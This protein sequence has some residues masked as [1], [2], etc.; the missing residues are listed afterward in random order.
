MVMTKVGINVEDILEEIKAS[1]HPS[2]KGRD[3]TIT[4][5]SGEVAWLFGIEQTTLSGWVRNNVLLPCGVTP[6]GETLF[7]STDVARLL[8]AFGA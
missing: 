7:L 4:L 3:R 5:T 8:E 2:V 6:Y 1:N